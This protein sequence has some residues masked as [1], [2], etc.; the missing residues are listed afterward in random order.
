[1]K[2]LIAN[3][4]EIAVRIHR[5]AASL[6]WPTVAA[7]VPADADTLVVAEADETYALPGDGVA[8]YLDVEAV[9]DAALATGAQAVHPGYGFLSE[10]PRLAERCAEAGLVFVGPD[11]D[12]LRLFGDKAGARDHAVRLGVPVLPATPAG[13]TLAD[14]GHFLAENPSGIMLKATAGGGGRGMR[15]VTE[16]AALADAYDRCR[17]EAQRSFGNDTLYAEALLPHARHLEVQVLGDGSRVVHLG[18]RDCSLQRRHQKVVEYAPSPALD[19]ST[20]KALHDAA[21]T[22]TEAVPYR[23]LATVE[24]LVDA[25]DPAR[26]VFI[27]VNPRVQVEHTVTEQVTGV[28]L[29][30]AQLRLA[31]GA[32]LAE[33][34]LDADAPPSGDTYAI[35]VRVNAERPLT[36]GSVVAAT[37]TVTAFE[38]PTSPTVRVDT[39]V[40]PGLRVDGTF[41]PLLA[42]LVTTTAGTFA[43]AC[44]AAEAAVRATVLDGV[45]TN[46]AMAARVL[47]HPEVVSGRATTTFLARHPELSTGQRDDTPVPGDTAS[48]TA[49]FSGSVVAVDVSP[50][51]AVAAGAILLV[52]E[53]MKMEHPVVAPASGTVQEVLVAAGDQVGDGDLL[54]VIEP[55]DVR[56][57]E[58]EDPERLD[59]THIRPDLAE[60]LER[61]RLTRDEARPQ[62]VEKRRARGHRTARENVDAL[63]DDGSFVEYGALPVAA[64]RTRRSLDDLVTST[65]ADG[66]VTG[67]ATI[68]AADHGEDSSRVAV[69]A[70]DYTVLAGTQGYFSH[71]KTDRMLSVAARLGVPVVLFAE[72]GGGRPGD[73][74]TTAVHT[75]GLDVGTFAAMGALSGSVPTV[76]VLNGRCFAGN[77]ALLGCCDVIVATRDSSLGM[78]G[79][80]MIEGGG[81]GRYAPEEVGP[82]SV[83]GPNGVVDVLVDDDA[84]AVAVAK[85]YLSYFQ[86]PVARWSAP[87]QRLLRHV[88]GENRLRVYDVLEVVRTLADSDSVLEL[89]A[90]FGRGM[91]TALVRI[92]GRPYGIVAND[93]THLGGAI[94]ADGAD[95]LARFLQLCDAHGLPVVSLCDTPG[96]MVGPE[97][98]R[99]ATVRH[100]SRLFVIGSHLRVPVTTIVLRKAYG[101]GAQAM[102]AGGF[103][104]PVA[105]AAWPTGEIGAMGLEGAVRLG[106]SRELAAIDDPGE[107]EERFQ[108]L[109]AE[110]YD[111]GKAINAA[112]TFE[113][114]DVIDPADTRR[115]LVATLGDHRPGTGGSRGYVDTW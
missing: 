105:T 64:Q 66:I 40:R 53:S 41:D 103:H 9:V 35:Q 2:I 34:G 61:H 91:V 26:F 14:A 47:A 3:R 57:D 74:D 38:T 81:L 71:K 114:D 49:S 84:E 58:R 31:A 83:Q 93:P 20:R 102:A 13:I 95:K 85:K 99:T 97:A 111:A 80:A 22:L 45:E 75:A 88:I 73:T 25:D 65:P 86:G 113:L 19:G 70:Y 63:C 77:A 10:D 67:L 106:Y 54:V 33:I 87:D 12:V 5:A 32:T 29:V 94:D 39:H 68:N 23:G 108:Q 56:V 104:R 110:H 42:K 17:S 7:H 107:R 76:G 21:I 43:E 6:G 18:E 15:S 72:G 89:R 69:L 8:G 48:V 98:E 62:A 16:G 92:E 24:M 4:G 112:M 78:A 90:E 51:D 11:A 37:G 100:F 60:V 27:E 28:D 79:P 96:F 59:P 101:L 50:G 115:W 46:L 36:D 44:A 109:V 82:M 1:M 52:L 55:G 30:S